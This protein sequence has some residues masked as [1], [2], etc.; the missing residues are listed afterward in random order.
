MNSEELGALLAD[1][2]M[3][4]SEYQMDRFITIKSGLTHWG[5][6]KQAIRELHKRFR[7]L[8]GLYYERRKAHLEIERDQKKPAATV[9]DADLRDLEIAKR[10]MDLYELEANIKDSEREFRHFY[11]QAKAL[12]QA[13]G[14]VTDEKRQSLEAQHWAFKTRLMAASDMIVRGRLSEATVEMLTC[15]AQGLKEL[16]VTELRQEDKKSLLDWLYQHSPELPAYELKDSETEVQR[17]LES[18]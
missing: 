1:H 12:K 9:I 10:K 8:K 11:A 3:Y 5:M 14:P 4:H 17:L 16:I 6:Y 7:G 13:I 2:Q 15:Q 18:A